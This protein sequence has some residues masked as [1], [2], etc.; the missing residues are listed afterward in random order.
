MKYATVSLPDGNYTETDQTWI[1]VDK[2][3]AKIL[4]ESLDEYCTKH[5]QS[6]LAKKMLKEFDNIPC[7]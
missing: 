7:L 5:K 1:L 2:K 3:E 6:K 4:I